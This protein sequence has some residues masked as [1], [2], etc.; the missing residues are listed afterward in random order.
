ML[1]QNSSHQPLVSI[2]IIFLNEGRFL[3]EAIESVL[4]QSYLH[5]ELFLVDD[6]STD[7]SS[8]VAR[9]YAARHPQ[10]IRYLEHPD[11]GNMGMSA[12]R[13]LGIAHAS[14]DL[15][16]FLDG[17]DVWLP[18][19]LA[20]Q[21]ALMAAHPDVAMAYGRTQIWYSWTNRPQDANRD[22]LKV[23]GTNLDQRIE[24]PHLLREFLQNEYICP[25]ICSL[26]VRRSV[27][28]AVGGWEDSFRNQYE[29][30][31]FY[32][33]V[34]RHYPVYV[35][36]DL[37]ARY[38]QHPDNNWEIL[39]RGRRWQPNRLKPSRKI[40]LEWVL[41]FLQ[42]PAHADAELAQLVYRNLWPYRHPVVATG[43]E[44]AE[45]LSWRIKKPY[46]WLKWVWQNKVL[47]RLRP[48]V[49][50]EADHA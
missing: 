32:T 37:Y 23:A 48:A 1:K 33:K 13:N 18:Q 17:D 43:L 36:S 34:T 5:W 9:R 15:V 40:Y 3:H 30:M 21:V 49:Q 2:I 22:Y 44:M 46:W 50:R 41:A 45:R 31:V 16:A 39:R 14:G 35:T 26:I 29:D 10:Q 47:S 11:H 38:R 7:A 4:A 6:G 20:Q 25:G 19:K 8:D 24:P 28:D 12:S 42:T 27:V